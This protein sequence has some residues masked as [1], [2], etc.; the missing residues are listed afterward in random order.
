MNITAN[1]KQKEQ[2]EYSLVKLSNPENNDV[3][4]EYNGQDYTLPTTLVVKTGDVVQ[5]KAKDQKFG[6]THFM[7]WQGDIYSANSELA[8]KVDKDISLEINSG[9]AAN[10]NLAK[11]SEVTA[12]D[13][14]EAPPT[15]SKNNLTDG[16]ISTGYTTN[17][18]ANVQNGNDIS[19][20]PID[21]T[22]NLKE[23]KNF[24]S[25]SIDPRTDAVTADGKTPNF[26]TDFII[27]TS[28]GWNKLY[29]MCCMYRMIPTLW[30]NLKC[31]N[32]NPKM[33]NTF[34]YM[35]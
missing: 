32:L 16:N 1:F 27:Q 21:I 24:N 28:T 18:I 25:I 13:S 19:D 7:N 30:E 4:V 10:I 12:T 23:Q 26:P 9:Y 15:W 6:I 33:H 5:L 22:L 8:V 14:M 35:C 34:V 11:G 2:K 17:V 20:H 29:S 31:M 3:I